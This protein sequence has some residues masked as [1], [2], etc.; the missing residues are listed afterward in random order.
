MLRII[1]LAVLAITLPAMPPPFKD[2]KGEKI[3]LPKPEFKGL[4]LEEALRKR[5]SVREYTAKP[6]TLKALSQLLFSAQGVTGNVSGTLLRTAPSAGAL[7]PC[8]VYIIVNNVK[9]LKKGIYHYSVRDHSI[10][11]MKEGDFRKEA[12]NASL[13]QEAVGDAGAVFVLSAAFDRTRSKY[14]DRGMRYIY[15]E[16]GHINQNISL[17]AAS[18]GLGSVVIGAFVDDDMNALVM[19]DG[20]KEA[21]IVIQAVGTM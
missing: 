4:S 17:Q 19:V 12:M 18:L 9:G 5:R 6:L 11:L 7:Y 13:G 3:T 2:Y 21:V 8:E 10:V 15:M 16:A 1:A 20:K 14:G